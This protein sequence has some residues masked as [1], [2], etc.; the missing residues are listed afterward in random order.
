MAKGFTLIINN[1]SSSITKADKSMFLLLVKLIVAR[2]TP[3]I[4]ITNV[5]IVSINKL[6]LNDIILLK[7]NNSIPTIIIIT[8]S[9]N[10]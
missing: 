5:I 2:I 3:T 1:L 6:Y 9:F 8:E 10:G 4:S 7:I